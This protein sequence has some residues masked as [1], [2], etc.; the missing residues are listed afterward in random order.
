M[1]HGSDAGTSEQ[2]HASLAPGENKKAMGMPEL[3]ETVSQRALLLI[4]FLL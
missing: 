4:P 2:E 1:L 3:W